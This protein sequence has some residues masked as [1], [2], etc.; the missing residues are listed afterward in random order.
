VEGAMDEKLTI[1]KYTIIK[2]EDDEAIITAK[3]KRWPVT[4]EEL[5]KMFELG[6]EIGLNNKI[7]EGTHE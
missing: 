7:V 5:V 3:E 1:G 6:I 2:S 4:G